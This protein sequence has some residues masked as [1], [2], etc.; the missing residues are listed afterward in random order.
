MKDRFI[1]AVS[2]RSV[3][4]IRLIGT[5]V[6]LIL[7]V[8][9]LSQQGWEQILN[10]FRR[11][12]IWILILSQGLIFISR[13]NISGRW[14]VLLR[15]TG[16]EISVRQS[17]RITFAGLF[18]SN[19]LPT[20]IGGDVVRLAGVL[21][22]NIDSAVSTASLIVD[23]L[24][25]MAGMGMVLL[26]SI[27]VLLSNRIFEGLDI[28]ASYLGLPTVAAISIG[29]WWQKLRDSSVRFLCRLKEALSIWISHPRGLLKSLGYTWVH[30][31]CIFGSLWLLLWGL[32]EDVS[33][34]MVGGLYSIVY[35]ITLLPLSINGYGIQEVAMMYML[36]SVGEVSMQSGLTVALLFRTMMIL[37]SIPGA[38]FLSDLLP[39]AK[40]QTN[41]LENGK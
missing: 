34:I 9:L 14:H 35:F 26:I 13:F 17:T 16:A 21:Q 41:D 30:M 15:S 4:I 33:F 31:L 10:A 12:P 24:V 5:L 2:G 23:R 3:Y 25:G 40:V 27:P 22:L 28:S 37:A 38:F 32:G 29:H 8:Y 39:G 6:A 11:I 19:F 20:T 1:N 18:A 36:S 7:L